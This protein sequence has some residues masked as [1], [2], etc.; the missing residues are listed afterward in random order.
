MKVPTST[1]PG[2]SASSD[3]VERRSASSGPMT[4]SDTGARPAVGGGLVGDDG[5]LR[6]AGD[7]GFVVSG[8][9][10]AVGGTPPAR[11]ELSQEH[12]GPKLDGSAGRTGPHRAVAAD[13]AFDAD[14]SGS[15]LSQCF[16][17]RHDLTV[18]GLARRRGCD[19]AV[20]VPGEEQ[21]AERRIAAVLRSRPP[22][23]RLVLSPGQGHIGE[24]EI[25]AALLGDVLGELVP[26]ARSSP[27]DV[28]GSLVAGVR[29]VE[30]RERILGDV[31]WF[32]EV[33]VVDDRD[34]RVPCC[35]GW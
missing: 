8:S 31:A 32:P 20:E 17:A 26:K 24:A 22:D 3:G 15:G 11:I 9:D 34:T 33:G 14:A 16:A 6:L 21:T 7:P 13:R 19:V 12:S 10:G 25:L 4:T 23:N 18:F 1:P 35:D 2:V 27:P 28:D 5:Q 30:D 29:V